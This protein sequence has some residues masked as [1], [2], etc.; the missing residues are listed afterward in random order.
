MKTVWGGKGKGK[1][2]VTKIYDFKI[3]FF[4][5]MKI[6]RTLEGEAKKLERKIFRVKRKMRYTAKTK[7][8]L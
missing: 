8:K 4:E 1:C 7:L 5:M 6:C 3:T 2:L